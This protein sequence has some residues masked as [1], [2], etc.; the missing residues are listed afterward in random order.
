MGGMKRFQIDLAAVA[1]LCEYVKNHCTGHFKRA[2]C[3][4]VSYVSINLS[5][6]YGNVWHTG[7][8][9]VAYYSSSPHRGCLED[10]P[11]VFL[12]YTRSPCITDGDV[13]LRWVQADK[14]GRS[15]AKRIT[16][17]V[18]GG[19]CAGRVKFKLTALPDALSVPP[20]LPSILPDGFIN[21][22][23]KKKAFSFLLLA[24]HLCPQTPYLEHTS[25][26]QIKMPAATKPN[27]TLL[28]TRRAQPS[29]KFPQQRMWAPPTGTHPH[30]GLVPATLSLDTRKAL[31]TKA[32]TSLTHLCILH[33]V[34]EMS[35]PNNGHPRNTGFSIRSGLQ[36]M[37]DSGEKWPHCQL[38][39]QNSQH[40]GS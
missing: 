17:Q 30:H 11:L 35:E 2:N 36:R 38:V 33:N 21:F 23:L 7:S 34:A 14:D 16:I 27:S 3:C 39:G 6:N 29:S 24:P 12:Q 28:S 5:P 15:D 32:K 37:L 18:S 31:P 10:S 19:H 25:S 13:S 4:Y 22:A 1:Q 26:K 40:G 9:T 8:A 20:S